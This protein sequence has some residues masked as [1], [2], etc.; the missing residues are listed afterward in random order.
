MNVSELAEKYESA[1]DIDLF[2]GGLAEKTANGALLGPTL[3]CIFAKQMQK[4][5]FC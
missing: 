3:S 5:R 1:E 2:V 4:V